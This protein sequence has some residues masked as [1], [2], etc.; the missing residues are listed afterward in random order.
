MS[1]YGYTRATT[2]YLDAIGNDLIAFKNVISPRPFT[3]EVLEQALTFAHQKHPNL[4]KSTPTLMNIMKQP[5]PRKFII[6]HLLGTHIDYEFRYPMKFAKYNDPQGVPS[7]VKDNQLNQY[8]T[9]DNAVLYND[10]AFQV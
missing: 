3:I 5:S 2:P 8:N 10:F 6:V 7:W 1:L 9:Y 4:F